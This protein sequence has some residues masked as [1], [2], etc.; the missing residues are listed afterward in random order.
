[1]RHLFAAGLVAACVLIALPAMAQ[2]VY[3]PRIMQFDSVD[4]ATGVSAYKVEFWLQAADPVT[5]A[6]IST[7][8]LPKNQVTPSGLAA[9]EPQ[10]QANL[11]DLTPLVGIP[12]G[13]FYVARVV[14]VGIDGTS[15][16]ERSPASNPFASA[17]V[18]NSVVNL[19]VR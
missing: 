2:A 15:L 8:D 6:P 7:Y 9:P 18:P 3:N 11:S 17:G 19:R 14:A 5:G 16:S 10:W 12:V 13:Q 4:H 1:M